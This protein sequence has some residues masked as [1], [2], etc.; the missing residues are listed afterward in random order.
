MQYLTFIAILFG[1]YLITKITYFL[2]KKVF[3]VLS[4]KT[5]TNVDDL[6]VNALEKPIIFA[7]F[8]LGFHYARYVLTLS[9]NFTIY[10]DNTLYSLMV[11]VVV[12]FIL[13]FVDAIMFHNFHPTS[14]NEKLAL[15]K[16]IYPIV[17]K[18][19]NFVI[20]AI[21]LLMI[22]RNLGYDIT[23]LL[24]GLGIGGLA[25]ALAAQDILSNMFGGA[26]LLSDKP[27]KVGDRILVDGKDGFVEVIGLR[28]TVLTTWDGT[29]I[30]VPNRK[31]ADS[32]VENI[33]REKA[34]RVKLILGVEY[35]TSTKKLEK[36]KKIL[37]DIVLKNKSTDDNSLIHFV[38]FNEYSLDIQ[39]IYWIKDL[40]KILETKDEINFEIKKAFEKEKI[41]FAFPSQTLYLKK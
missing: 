3:R 16:S 1:T 24:A 30:I 29:Q 26:A 27:F 8:I 5:K 35:S 13:K 37:S 4:K 9:E 14:S 34:R 18:L 36:T 41:E 32:V 19:V 12:W 20:L 10:Y 38:N 15:D 21:A 2:F 17:K 40:D 39:L 33:S 22:I 7:I 11:I 25:F 6:L 23:S 28:S 31:I